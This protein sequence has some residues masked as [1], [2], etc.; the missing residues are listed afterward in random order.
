MLLV[1][2]DTYAP[3][4]EHCGEVSSLQNNGCSYYLLLLVEFYIPCCNSLQPLCPL[5][6]FT[7][8]PL[9]ATIASCNFTS[10]ATVTVH[11]LTVAHCNSTVAHCIIVEF[12]VNSKQRK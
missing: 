1:V 6:R 12:D 11:L 4:N 10:A 3:V 5:L 8:T 9:L 7:A 2:T